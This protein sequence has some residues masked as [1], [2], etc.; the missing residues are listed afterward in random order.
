MLG[1][2]VRHYPDQRRGVPY[3]VAS[4]GRN[5]GDPPGRTGAVPGGYLRRVAL[6]REQCRGT[7]RKLCRLRLYQ[8]APSGQIVNFAAGSIALQLVSPRTF[9]IILYRASGFLN[10]RDVIWP[11]RNS[12]AESRLFYPR[13]DTVHRLF[14]WKLGGRVDSVETMLRQCCSV[15]VLQCIARDTHSAS[16][17]YDV[18]A[19]EQWLGTAGKCWRRTV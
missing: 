10:G 4:P 5:D 8:L 15:A 9:S 11:S 7:D 14:K 6:T 3:P 2:R 19:C 1:R 12:S 13:L 18:S 17:N 16:K